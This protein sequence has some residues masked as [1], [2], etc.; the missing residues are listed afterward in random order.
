MKIKHL[1]IIFAIILI[2]CSSLADV[3]T[4]QRRVKFQQNQTQTNITP[5]KKYNTSRP[6]SSSQVHKNKPQNPLANNIKM[7]KP[8]SESLSTS[9]LGMDMKYKISIEG[10]VNN[11]CRLNFIA[12]VGGANSSFPSLYGIEA[13]DA[14]IL[15][16]A[17]KIQCNFTKQQ[18]EYV[19]DSIL[20]ENERNNGATN[21]MLKDPNDIPLTNFS[22]SDQRLL[23]VILNQ[24]AC[25][26]LN[27]GDLNNIMQMLY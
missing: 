18:L 27:T 1:L 11:K 24:K 23:E 14:T 22:A 25:T 9:Y 15:S 5:P 12:N 19:G 2:G 17:P 6:T 21:N 3:V 13:S 10:W 16:F 8:Y 7:C 20:Q 4:T 26:I